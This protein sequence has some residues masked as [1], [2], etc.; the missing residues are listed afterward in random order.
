MPHPVGPF[1]SE[2][3]PLPVRRFE[4]G[5][6][7]ADRL[8]VG[9]A[10]HRARGVAPFG[11]TQSRL[12]GPAAEQTF[13]SVAAPLRSDAAYPEQIF[14]SRS[15]A[16]LTATPAAGL[17]RQRRTEQR[18]DDAIELLGPGTAACAALPNTL[19]SDSTSV[20]APTV[21]H[22]QPIPRRASFGKRAASVGRTVARS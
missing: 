1:S 9:R 6:L 17:D 15:S 3:K 11:T 12:V 14:V 22:T 8:V 16:R 5:L 7:V 21:R 10:P 19:R 20:P 4:Y 13:P 18:P 2:R